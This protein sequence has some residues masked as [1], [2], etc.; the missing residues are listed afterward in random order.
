MENIYLKKKVF[1]CGFES[2]VKSIADVG[3]KFDIIVIDGRCR[4]LAFE[5]SKKFLKKVE[6]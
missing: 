5:Y 1:G 2:Y 4:V 3:K 6:L